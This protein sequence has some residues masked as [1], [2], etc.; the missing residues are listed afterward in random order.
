MSIF[1]RILFGI[2]HLFSYICTKVEIYMTKYDKLVEIYQWV[3]ETLEPF[4]QERRNQRT[5]FLLPVYF[6]V[7]DGV[8]FAKIERHDGL[9]FGFV[10][11][12]NFTFGGEEVEYGDVFKAA[13]YKVP[14][15]K[16]RGNIFKGTAIFNDYGFAYYNEYKNN[17]ITKLN[18]M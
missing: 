7:K 2:V 9:A 15:K 5:P 6:E 11:L 4:I 3:K 14:A 1:K 17:F 18:L 10:A 13:S 16:K 8:K 12:N